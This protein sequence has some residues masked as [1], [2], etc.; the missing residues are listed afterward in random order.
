MQYSS[1]ET[2][3]SGC[4]CRQGRPG[5]GFLP[6]VFSL[7]KL[8]STRMLQCRSLSL[9]SLWQHSYSTVNAEDVSDHR[10]HSLAS[11]LPVF[12]EKLK[13][14]YTKWLLRKLAD[15]TA[16]EEDAGSL[17]IL[18]S[19]CELQQLPLWLAE[20]W[21]L[22]QKSH[23]PNR[24]A[25]ARAATPEEAAGETGHWEDTDG[26]HRLPGLLR[27]LGLRQGWALSLQPSPSPFFSP[28]CQGQHRE[29]AKN[30]LVI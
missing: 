30:L 20:T 17:L 6:A 27:A 7:S 22:W 2:R 8:R 3:C 14:W 1:S 29:G 16:R 5:W 23:S 28:T 12:C 25:S 9:E 15:F 4:H 26:Q 11:Q 19:A 10:S 18:K 21:R 13:K 24:P